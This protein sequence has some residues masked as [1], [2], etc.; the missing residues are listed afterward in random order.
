MLSAYCVPGV[1]TYAVFFS[2]ICSRKLGCEC[3]RFTE[4]QGSRGQV[5]AQLGRAK[6]SYLSASL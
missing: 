4:E 1:S 6:P 5:F 3:D 2:V